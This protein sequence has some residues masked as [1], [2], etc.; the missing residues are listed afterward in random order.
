MDQGLSTSI[1]SGILIHPTVWPQYT[2]VTDRQDRQQSNSIGQTVFGRPFVKWFALC[3]QTVVCPVCL[4]VC[5]S[6]CLCLSV[7]N[8]GVL[9]PNGWTDRDETWHAGRPR[10]WPHCVRLGPSSPSPKGH[11]PQ[12]SAHLLRP[13]SCMDQDVTWYGANKS[14]PRRLLVR[15]GPHTPSTKGGGAPPQIFGPCLLWPNGWMDE[16]G[17]WHGGRPQ[18]RRL[19]VRWGPSPTPQKGAKPFPNFQPISILAKRLDASRCHLVW[20]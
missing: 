15:L 3:Y 2:K 18:P 11:S 5:M 1:P 7:C 20:R 6:V 13:N 14:R 17:T 8:V 4:C 19:C 10:P 9:W 12:F 16:A